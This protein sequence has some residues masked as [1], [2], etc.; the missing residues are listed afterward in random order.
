MYLES[1]HKSNDLLY[2]KAIMNTIT[3]CPDLVSY[4]DFVTSMRGMQLKPLKHMWVL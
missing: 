3:Y 1:I 2:N 4:F